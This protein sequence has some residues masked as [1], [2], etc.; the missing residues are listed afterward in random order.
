MTAVIVL[1]QYKVKP[2]QVET[3]NQLV[4]AVHDELREH[5]PGD[6]RYIIFQLE[7]VVSFIHLNWNDRKD[8]TNALTE[9]PAFQRFQ[10]GIRER[11][12]EAGAAVDRVALPIDAE[13]AVVP[14]AADHHVAPARPGKP[15]RACAARDRRLMPGAT[16]HA[17][18]GQ[19]VVRNQACWRHRA[20]RQRPRPRS[21]PGSWWRR[22]RH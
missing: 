6:T 22:W 5:Q 3:N 2:D 14:R 16:T 4:T 21:R 1:L 8:G 13:D 7:D 10:Q 17:V 11:V 15:V 19:L 18:A 12:E 9:L 20:G